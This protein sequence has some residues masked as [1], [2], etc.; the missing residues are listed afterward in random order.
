MT[1]TPE[2][3]ARIVHQILTNKKRQMDTTY[4][5]FS[6]RKNIFHTDTPTLN[7]LK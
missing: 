2:D 4:I 7:K 5:S 6:S 1:H 3:N